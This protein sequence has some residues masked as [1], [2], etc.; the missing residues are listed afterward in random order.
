MNGKIL[1]TRPEHDD[2]THYLSNWST[3]IIELAQNKD[4]KVLDLNRDKAV[5]DKVETMLTKQKPEMVIFNGHGNN[6]QVGGHQDKPLISMGHNEGLLRDKTT[7]AISCK[8]AKE[9]GPKAVEK[10]AKVY[11][12]YEEDFV[13]FYDPKKITNPL[14]DQT[15]KLFLEPSNELAFSLIKGNTP[16]ES[17]RRSQEMFKRNIRRLLS[18]KA[19]KEET[20]MA[21]YLWWDMK[22]QVCIE[23]DSIL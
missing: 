9:L 19:T 14:K 20:S 21:R 1:I 12:G 22:H 23:E 11:I 4:L 8:S 10:G 7:Y 16:K 6:K 18:S 3:K 13:F 15:A 2:T 17:C 5:A